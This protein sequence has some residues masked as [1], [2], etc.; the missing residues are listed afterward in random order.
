MRNDTPLNVSH[1][2]LHL[3]LFCLSVPPFSH[4]P[5]SSDPRRCHFSTCP[6]DALRPSHLSLS[7]DCLVQPLS[8]P[9]VTPLPLF[10]VAERRDSEAE[11][12]RIRPTL[13]LN[14]F[15]TI[16]FNSLQTDQKVDTWQFQIVSTTASTVEAGSHGSCS[17]TTAKPWEHRLTA[18][19]DIS[20]TNLCVFSQVFSFS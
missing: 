14:V 9:A 1:C 18:S 15:N 6:P 4:I 16:Q 17:E 11:W 13:W 10:T 19:N 7:P 8:C 3:S 2:L 5:T 12:A 20:S